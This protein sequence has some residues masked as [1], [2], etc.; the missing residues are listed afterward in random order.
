MTIRHLAWACAVILWPA[1]LSAAEPNKHLPDDTRAVI[2]INVR[3]LVKSPILQKHAQKY[4]DEAT[5]QPG[6]QAILDELDLNPVQDIQR[7]VFSSSDPKGL[8][9]GLARVGKVRDRH[10]FMVVEG[11]FS[12]DKIRKK[13]DELAKDNLVKIE[14]IAEQDVCVTALPQGYFGNQTIYAAMPDESTLLVA[15]SRNTM[16]EAIEKHSGKRKP[17]L[18]PKMQALIEKTDGEQSVWYA[19]QDDEQLARALLYDI[20]ILHGSKEGRDGVSMNVSGGFTLAKD[21]K[22]SL[23]LDVDTGDNAKTLEKHLNVAANMLCGITAY[24]SLQDPGKHADEMILLSELFK[25]TR[26]SREDKRIVLTG[27]LEGKEIDRL[28][29]TKEKP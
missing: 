24:F 18:D 4:V 26:I 25:A 23:I 7:I 15:A 22:V 5:K 28:M 6:I 1:A 10:D 12:R 21:A 17:K 8:M 16:I 29:G 3:Q 20:Y 11:R 9:H 2:S 19:V 13:V 27:S 14:K